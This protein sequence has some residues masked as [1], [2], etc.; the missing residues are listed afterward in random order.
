M[1][2]SP[3]SQPSTPNPQPFQPIMEMI[4][5][6]NPSGVGATVTMPGASFGS[7]KPDTLEM[8][9]VAAAY[10]KS[11]GKGS[12]RYAKW[13]WK[14]TIL[15]KIEKEPMAYSAIENKAFA[16]LGQGIMYVR[17]ADLAAGTVKRHHDPE[18]ERLLERNAMETDFLQ[19]QAFDIAGLYNN[20][21]Q[22]VFNISRTKILQLKHLEAEYSAVSK[23]NESKK[24]LDRKNIYYSGEFSRQMSDTILDDPKKTTVLDLYDP[25]NW[26]FFTENVKKK[27]TSFGIQSRIKTPRSFF[28]STPIHLGLFRDKGWVDNNIL[29]PEVVH[30]MSTNQ[31]SLKYIIYISVEYFEALYGKAVWLKFTPEEQKAKFEAL[32]KDIEN[33]LVG[34]KNVFSSM[35][36]LCDRDFQGNLRK[37][38]QIE[39]IDD[40]LKTDSWV[41]NSDH[42]NQN[43]IRGFNVPTSMYGLSNSNLR[44]NTQSGSANREGFNNMVTLNT[45]VQR[46][47]LAPL[48]IMADFNAANGWSNWDVKFFIDDITHTT[49]NNQET[50]I[51][52]SDT[53]L[54][55]QK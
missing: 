54:N 35:T 53:A 1:S 37:T 14:K 9:A 55:I 5:E 44:M 47:L 22:A 28:Y 27:A 36:L 42:G 23:F 46:L 18:I 34:T 31:I 3:Q 16:L 48:Q 33:K 21:S 7:K 15:D 19:A 4:V 25:L 17:K 40:K 32:R 41:P 24:T 38:I 8:P 20:F 13:D 43:I 51:E 6:A 45:P 26:N 12:D 49:I 39:A 52:K 30:A 2:K 50:G 10:A 11:D 29:V